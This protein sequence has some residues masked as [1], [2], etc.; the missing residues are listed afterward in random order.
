M[1]LASGA[2]LLLAGV[3]LAVGCSTS[4]DAADACLNGAKDEGEVGADCGG[5]CATKCT[6]D[7]CD[8]NEVCS[9]ARCEGGVC[10]PKAGKPCGVGVGTTCADGQSCELDKDCNSGFCE[11]SLKCG[12]R[13]GE[14]PP[15]ATDGKKNNDETD[16]DCGGTGAPPCANGK[17][18]ASDADC[19]DKYCPAG[20][21]CVEPRTDDGVKNG[22]ETDVDCGGTSGKLC[23]EA[24]DCVADT[25]CIGA[26]SYAKKCVDAPS[27]KPHI[28]GDTCGVG[29]VGQ[30]GAMHQSC[31]RSLP[32]PGFTDATRPGKQVYLDK[33]EITAGRVR[34]FLEAIAA[35][36][37][38]VPNV[39]A[40]VTANP[41]PLWGADWSQ[42]LPT[43]FETE[44]LSVPHKPTS[45]AETAPWF[46][47][48]GVNWQFNE[49]LYVYVHGHNCGT[50]IGSYGYP[51]FFY[52][53]AVMA[54][55][56]DATTFPPRVDGFDGAGN[57]I[58]AQELLDAK[59][60]N[61]IP[62]AM[63]AAFCHWDG[64]Q[65]ATDTVLD[66]VTN[67]P[68]NLGSAA[69][70]GTRCA[71]V[72]QVN[73][74][75]DSGTWSPI[76]Y[77]FPYYPNGTTSESVSRISPPGRASLAAAAGGQPAD[78]VRINAGDEPWMDL[79]GNVHE[80]ALDVTVGQAYAGKFA[81]KYRG[82]GYGSARAGGNN[83]A[84]NLS[85]PEYKAGYSGGRCMR[86]K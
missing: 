75:S 41:P 12:V 54:K 39:K 55:Y 64:G 65:L 79:H 40:W 76:N 73:A 32:V 26:C 27:C 34:A 8:V 59:A 53:G 60:M 49:Q 46:R 2:A 58:P 16:V 33:Y 38:G 3:A 83:A 66:F 85:Y 11:P 43:G 18:C 74:T 13:P 82:I 68:A 86:F 31:C 78:V 80:V 52:S 28:G 51:T 7:A 1:K 37:G 61:C 25:D 21:L 50:R 63:L 10:A 14:L 57:K 81:L 15:S 5:T 24:K 72:A 62:N 4:G 84:G 29:E 36:N 42:F 67:A 23:T 35:N 77:N 71:P 44:T 20:G 48:A 9:S 56:Q 30:A 47:N 45:G 70:C 69:G 22:T 19:A 6:G 17:G